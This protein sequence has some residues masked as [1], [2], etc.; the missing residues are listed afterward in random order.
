M[1]HKRSRHNTEYV[2]SRAKRAKKATIN[3]RE[4]KIKEREANIKEREA[5]IREIDAKIREIDANKRA[6]IA[7]IKKMEAEERAKIEKKRVQLEKKEARKKAQIEQKEARKKVSISRRKARRKAK[8]EEEKAKI[9]E[10]MS[11][12]SSLRVLMKYTDIDLE[13]KE[14]KRTF[15]FWFKIDKECKDDTMYTMCVIS[16]FHRYYG[17]FWHPSRLNMIPSIGLKNNI[18]NE[19]IRPYIAEKKIQ[20]MAFN[21]TGVLNQDIARYGFMV[22]KYSLWDALQSCYSAHYET[23]KDYAVSVMSSFTE[24]I[25]YVRTYLMMR[26]HKCTKKKITKFVK[27]KCNV[28][29]DIYQTWSESMLMEHSSFPKDICLQIADYMMILPLLV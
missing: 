5:K 15:G 6:K 26:V 24:S 4:A 11:K 3:E 25:E 2:Q 8:I 22:G 20:T 18:T 7:R 23:D 29:I 21:W 17:P 27:N 13:I 16:S 28:C 10:Y 12:V 9:D 19:M 1:S 14:N